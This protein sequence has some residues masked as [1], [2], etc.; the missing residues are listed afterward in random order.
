MKALHL[1]VAEKKNFEDRLLWF[2]VPTYVPQGGVS[3]ELG[4]FV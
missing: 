1:Q 3:F 2:Y 4:S